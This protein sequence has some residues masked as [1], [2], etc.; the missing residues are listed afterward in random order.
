MANVGVNAYGRNAQ[1]MLDLDAP[2][3]DWCPLAK[4]LGRRVRPART[5]EGF[6]KLFDGALSRKGPFLI[7][8]VID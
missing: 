5:I 4:G 6:V 3:L 8:A 2:K 1:R 7:E